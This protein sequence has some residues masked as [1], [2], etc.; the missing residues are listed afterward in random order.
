MP[1]DEKPEKK[2][3]CNSRKEKHVKKEDKLLMRKINARTQKPKRKT[4]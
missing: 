4:A 1:F 2:K 3:A